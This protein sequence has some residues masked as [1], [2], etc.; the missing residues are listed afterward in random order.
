MSDSKGG[1][2]GPSELVPDLYDVENGMREAAR[3]RQRRDQL[4]VS[5]GQVADGLA[6]NIA[7]HFGPEAAETAG[8]ALVLA[9]ASIGALDGVP[10]PVVA[11]VLALAGQRL[12]ADA[13]AAGTSDGAS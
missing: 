7:R 13:R 2:R 11:N 8:L 4:A 3:Y 1:M 12:A 9:G 10:V 5:T 6:A